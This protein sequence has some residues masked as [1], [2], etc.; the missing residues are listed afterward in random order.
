MY[1]DYSSSTPVDKRV[2]DKYYNDN[3]IYPGNAN[4]SH[5]LGKRIASEIENTSQK[6]IKLLNLSDDYEIIYTSGSTESNNLA[7]SGLIENFP[8]AHFITTKFEHSSVLAPISHYQKA[9]LSVDF[10]K[11]NNGLID[12]NHLESLIDDRITIVSF[13]SVNS[14]I[15]IKQDIENIK[16]LLVKYDNVYFHCDATQ[17][18][19]KVYIDY[20]NI[21]MI[22]FSAHKIYG[23]KGIGALIKKKRVPLKSQIKGGKSTTKYRSGTPAHPLIFSLGYALELITSE[24]QNNLNKVI[25]ISSYLKS[26]LNDIDYIIINSNE[27][28]VPHIVNFSIIG[29][30]S[31]DIVKMLSDNDVYISNHSACSSD[32]ELS[33]AVLELQNDTALAR[34]SVRVS[35]SH[36][37][38]KEEVDKLISLIKKIK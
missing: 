12:I 16:N 24:L 14:E 25:N 5:T 18:I 38:L 8:N 4:S 9:S 36:L 17:S 11:L 3:I 2:L 33:L 29:H 35:L 30:S 28:S 21:D 31:I 32:K 13:A 10:V 22:S 23:L 27:Y 34:S 1:L 7:I 6:I 37:T 15:G 26:C 20:T 19:G